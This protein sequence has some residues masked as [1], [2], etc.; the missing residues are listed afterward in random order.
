MASRLED[1]QGDVGSLYTV[2]MLFEDGHSDT[3]NLY[4]ETGLHKFEAT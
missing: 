1:R 4:E 2:P 3:I